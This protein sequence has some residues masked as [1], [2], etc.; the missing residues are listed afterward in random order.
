MRLDE[1]L[2]EIKFK[3]QTDATY[4]LFVPFVE[5]INYLSAPSISWLERVI[6]LW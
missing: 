3:I 4:G 5:K 2:S 1:L 6:Q